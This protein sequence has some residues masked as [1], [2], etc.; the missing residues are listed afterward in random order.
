MTRTSAQRDQKRRSVVQ[1]SRSREFN[2]RPRPL[3]LEHGD[4]LSQGEDFEGGVPATAEEDADRGEEGED[5]LRARTHPCNM[6]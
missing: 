1:K 6:A 5:E 4:L 3:A 2:G